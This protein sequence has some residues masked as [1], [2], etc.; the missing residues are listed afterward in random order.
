VG[1]QWR[2]KDDNTFDLVVVDNS[3]APEI[4]AAGKMEALTYA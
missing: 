1:G 3:H 4:P 2:R